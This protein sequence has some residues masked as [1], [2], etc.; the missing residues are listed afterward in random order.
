MKRITTALSVLCA[1]FV[2]AGVG[3]RLSAQ[4]TQP[5]QQRDLVLEGAAKPRL[6]TAVPR[7][8]ALVIGVAQY[9]NLEPAKQLRYPESD[10]A[11]VARVL[12]NREGGSFPPENVHLLQGK[13]ATLVN[14]R[15]ELEQWL[16][17]VAQPSDRVVVYFAGHGLVKNG[18]GF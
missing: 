5:P 13:D 4:G 10:A 3:A 8:Y 1:L 15:R 17:S 11:A 9:R 14:I 16:P 18:R 7:G 2:P 12:I 6:P